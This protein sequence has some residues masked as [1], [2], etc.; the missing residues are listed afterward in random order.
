[1]D[2]FSEE[3]YGNRKPEY[4]EVAVNVCDNCDR[5]VDELRR[6]Y[7]YGTADRKFYACDECYDE[8]QAHLQKQAELAERKPVQPELTGAAWVLQQTAPHFAAIGNGL[9][10]RTGNRRKR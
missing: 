6:V 8:I 4:E 9:F 5:A 7:E 10:V 3:L 2:R 1:M